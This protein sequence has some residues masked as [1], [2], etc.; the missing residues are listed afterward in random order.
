MAAPVS[1]R[2]GKSFLIAFL[3]LVVVASSGQVAAAAAVADPLAPP[4]NHV[5]YELMLVFKADVAEV[6]EGWTLAG[7][8]ERFPPGDG[9]GETGGDGGRRLS[10]PP[11]GLAPL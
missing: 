10:S 9:D 2:R 1:P 4:R 7:R 11:S 8:S 5:A 3:T 6:R